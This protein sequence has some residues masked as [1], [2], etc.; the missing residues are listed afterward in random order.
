MFFSQEVCAHVVTVR[1]G[2][3]EGGS[4]DKVGQVL[5]PCKGRKRPRCIPKRW[6]RDRP[7]GRLGFRYGGGAGGFGPA[8][9]LNGLLSL[10]DLKL[11]SNDLI[12]KPRSAIPFHLPSHPLTP[13]PR[14]RPYLRRRAP[15]SL[16]LC[17]FFKAKLG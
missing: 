16:P 13:V 11:K 4:I 17:P 8:A 14:R 9:Q 12:K 1:A 2:Q 5:V 15:R 6:E 7:S 3:L 10:V